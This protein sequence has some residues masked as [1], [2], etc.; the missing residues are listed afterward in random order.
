MKKIIFNKIKFIDIDDK[1]F[2]FIIN[3]DGLFVFP[4]GPGLASIESEFNY[5][6]SLRNSD[7]VFFDSGYFVLLLKI[8]KGISVKKFSGYKFLKIFL[9]FLKKKNNKV[10]LVDPSIKISKNNIRFFKNLGI[11]KV[12]SYIAPFYKKN[13]IIDTMLIRYINKFRPDN[14]IINLGG[15][16]QEVLGFYVKSNIKYK[17]KIICTGGAISYFTGDQAPIS[18][19]VDKYYLGWFFRILFKPKVFIPRYLSAILLSI[20]VFKNKVEIVK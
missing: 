18:S 3:R 6:E 4:S 11:N 7:Y 20:R 15:G 8:I 13:P 17:P 14:I 9:K 10:L 2:K 19:F 16:V 5:L 12:K 1:K